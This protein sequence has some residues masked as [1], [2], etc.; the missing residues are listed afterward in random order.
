MRLM[1]IGSFIELE[2]DKGKEYWKG[3]N[4]LRLNTGRAAIWHAFK[5][6]KCK[7]I[8]IPVY[9]CHTVTSFLNKHS[10]EIRYYNI[11][12]NF[13]PDLES[14]PKDF[15]ILIVNYFGIFSNTEMAARASR[16]KNVI[17][18]NCPAF[19][20]RPINGCQNVYSA[21]KFIGVPDGSYVIGDNI[22][23]E[24]DYAQD[25]SSDTSAFLLKR[26]EY[27]CEGKVYQERESNET[28]LDSSDAL[29]MSRLT[30]TILDGVDY[31][32]IKPIRRRNFAI[33]C[34]LFDCI[35]KIDV[36]KF[37]DESCI[38][39]VY[40]LMTDDER[41]MPRLISA[42]HFQGNWWRYILDLNTSNDFE[43]RLSKYMIPITIDQRYGEEHLNYIKDII[44]GK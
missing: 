15:S 41:L 16:F 7:G 20:A 10:V 1:E 37:Y 6:T 21:R 19:F 11:N 8:Y 40:P 14:I 25:F 33:A 23:S 38:P 32:S 36:R 18:D 30:H 12:E 42:K 28:R 29:K 9:Q 44:Y 22:T 5:A 26:I 27:G 13:E 3:D 17:I 4:V 31:K 39:M 35:N 24:C 2:F 34:S 43:K